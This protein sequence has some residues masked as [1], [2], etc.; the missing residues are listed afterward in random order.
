MIENVAGIDAQIETG[1]VA[2]AE[3]AGQGSIHAE[4]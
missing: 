2:C 4:L 3:R 1:P